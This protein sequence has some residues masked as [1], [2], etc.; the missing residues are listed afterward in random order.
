M[1][2][3][4]SVLYII[5]ERLY[6]DQPNS[7]SLRDPEELKAMYKNESQKPNIPVSIRSIQREIR[8][9]RSTGM[10]WEETEATSSFGLLILALKVP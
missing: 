7:D 9:A 5:P 4:F 2:D 3:E 10:C 6:V 1:K 8:R